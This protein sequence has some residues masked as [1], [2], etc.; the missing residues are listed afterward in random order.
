[1]TVQ[2][3]YVGNDGAGIEAERE[4]NGGVYCTADA[5]VVVRIE[6]RIPARKT[7]VCRDHALWLRSDEVPVAWEQCGENPAELVENR[8]KGT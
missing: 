1:M 3:Q 6:S 4:E 2:C 7:P 5:D 8:Q